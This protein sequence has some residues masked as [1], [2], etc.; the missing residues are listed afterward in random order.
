M[1]YVTKERKVKLDTR[2]SRT[3]THANRM[4]GPG[5]LNYLV[6]QLAI[7]YCKDN[8]LD[9]RTINDVMGGLDSARAEFYRRVAT[10]YEE[11]KAE[12]NGDV[13]EELLKRE[14]G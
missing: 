3:I 1:P 9:Y 4:K 10:P 5:E 2:L 14:L 7:A 11:G 13:F 6:T 12:V 8:G